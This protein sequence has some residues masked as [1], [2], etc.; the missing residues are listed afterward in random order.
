MIIRKEI[1]LNKPLTEEQ[2]NML[3]VLE[4][5]PV[6][7]D[8]D[9]PELTDE[10]LVMFAATAREKRKKNENKQTVAIRL[11]PQALTKAKSL[12]KGYTT[13]LSRILEAALNDNEIIKH[14]L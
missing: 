3:K 2:K 1:D 6:V 14:Y 10:Q 5:R 8:K 7:Q 12:G 13:V 9:C 4:T 11:S